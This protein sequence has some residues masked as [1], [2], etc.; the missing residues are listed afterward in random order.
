MAQEMAEEK[1]RELKQIY[2]EIERREMIGCFRSFV[3]KA[4]HVIEPNQKFVAGWH[5]D[6]VCLHLEAIYRRQIRN[7][8]INIP[9]RHAKSTICSVLFPAWVW[10]SRPWERFIFGSHAY[11]LSK[12]DSIKCRMLI[13]SAWYQR[14][15]G[16]SWRLALDQN[17]KMRFDNT[18][19]GY[20][21]ATSVGGSVVGQ[22]AD[23]LLVDDPNAPSQMGSNIQRDSV[24]SWYDEEFS[25][26]INDPRTACKIVIMQRL[27]Q[28][29]LSGHLLVKGGWEHLC[30]PA[31]YEPSTQTKSSIGW[32]DPRTEPDEPLWPQ[33]FGIQEIEEFKRNMGSSAAAGQLQQRP[34]PKEGNV[35]NR[36]WWKFYGELPAEFD[37]MA[38]SADLT[39]K[40]GEKTDFAVFQI[41]G[42]KGADKYLIDQV[43]ARMGFTAQLTT[44]RA[45]KGKYPM[46]NVGWVE[47]AANGAALIETLK[48]EISGIIPVKP[49]GSKLARAEAVA[50]QIEAGNVYL[51]DPTIA[52]WINDF[53]EE[54]AV[55][56]NGVHDDQ[57]DSCTMALNKMS[58]GL[59]FDWMPGSLTGASKFYGR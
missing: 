52:P 27:H 53:I 48:K 30:L 22:G 13:Q 3:E 46:M 51:P 19:Q 49:K 54:W 57:V 18:E 24:L 45:L 37:F 59:L 8:I 28:N 50:P 35:V 7:L 17:E 12:R 34:S 39:F 43:R 56:P 14:M 16:I 9:P 33:R 32:E 10:L 5:I 36:S 31:Q 55:F 23:I 20:R 58:E 15:F 21:I 47:E 25:T 2:L 38:L 26:R 1:I 40:D 6:A 41:W 29:D 4:W 42:R 44:F 11:S